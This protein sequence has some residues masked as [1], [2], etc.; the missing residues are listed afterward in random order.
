LCVGEDI[1]IGIVWEILEDIKV[2][3]TMKQW[4]KVRGN[5]TYTNNFVT[6]KNNNELRGISSR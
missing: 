4:Q 2:L 6:T 1:G 5:F 3:V